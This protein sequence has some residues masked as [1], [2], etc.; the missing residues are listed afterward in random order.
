[1]GKVILDKGFMSTSTIKGKEFGGEVRLEILVPA[2]SKG[3]YLGNGVSVVGE[4]ES[5]LLFDKGSR[6]KII[7][8][9]YDMWNNRII[10]ARMM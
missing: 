5:E 10:K 7:G 8:V 2:G 4:G 1:M 9:S 3:A 6:L